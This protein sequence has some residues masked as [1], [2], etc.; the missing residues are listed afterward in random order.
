MRSR[1]LRLARDE[2][3]PYLLDFARKFHDTSPYKELNFDQDKVAHTILHLI[4]NPV[5]LILVLGDTPVGCLAAVIE[6]TLFGN[7]RMAVEVMFWVELEHRGR[8]SFELPK[9]YE[10]W[11]KKLGCKVVT[12][13]S[14]EGEN[15]AILDRVYRGMKFAPCEHSYMKV[16]NG[17]H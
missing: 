17:S 2:D 14:L 5:G 4:H 8:N 1:M 3:L 9:A 13:S 10:F 6:D 11:A 16:L 7:D 12:L 15:T